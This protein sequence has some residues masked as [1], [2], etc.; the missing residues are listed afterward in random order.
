MSKCQLFHRQPSCQ[1]YE[2]KKNSTERA[3]RHKPYSK[4]G[5]SNA[6]THNKFQ[7][8]TEQL[9]RNIREIKEQRNLALSS[10]QNLSRRGNLIRRMF[11]K[12]FLSEK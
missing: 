10:V 7:N 11:T 2:T 5:Q 8:I 3:A 12:H 6:I 4:R 1:Y 9:A